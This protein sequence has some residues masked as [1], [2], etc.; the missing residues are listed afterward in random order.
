MLAL[1]CSEPPNEVTH[2]AGRVLAKRVGI[3]LL[4]LQ[5]I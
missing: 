1:T 4:D 5:R 3:F 2:W